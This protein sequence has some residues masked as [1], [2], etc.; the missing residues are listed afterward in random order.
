MGFWTIA[1]RDL[2]RHPMRTLL[3]VFSITIGVAAVISVQI[4]AE[5]ADRSVEALRGSVSGSFDLEI[6]Q[7]DGKRF[8][9]AEIEKLRGLP[10]VAEVLPFLHRTTIAYAK[11]K[12]I[13]A[14]AVGIDE[15]DPAALAD[16]QLTS[17]QSLAAVPPKSGEDGELQSPDDQPEESPTFPV[18]LESSFARLLG[19]T[20]GDQFTILLRKGSTTVRVVGLLDV[21]RLSANGHYGDIFLCLADL[22][23]LS[24]W[25]DKIDVACLVADAKTDLGKLRL[26]V[27]AA[28][29]ESLRVRLAGAQNEIAA[30]SMRAAKLGLIFAQSLAL[31]IAVFIILNNLLISVGQRRR[32][33][34][35]LRAVGATRWQILRIVLAEA[36]VFGVLGSVS[37][38]ALGILGA[39]FLGPALSRLWEA[40]VTLPEI[41]LMAVL[42]AAAL[43]PLVTLLGAVLPALGAT[44]VSPLEGI[45]GPAM[46]R[47]LKF[48]KRVVALAAVIWLLSFLLL[49][50]CITQRVAPMFSI[51]AGIGML[52]GFVLTIPPL[53]RPLGR[54]ISRLLLAP[55]FP[56]E[57]EIALRQLY[58]N[59]P[60]ATLT[61]AVIVIALSNGIGLGHTLI[62]TLADVQTWY[63]RTMS[64]DL[65]LRPVV[66]EQAA[67]FG[68]KDREFLGNRLTQ[69]PGCD[70]WIAFELPPDDLAT[71]TSR[72]SRA[73]L[74]RQPRYR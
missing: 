46:A 1:W 11:N 2:R 64:G 24:Y 27:A 43:G 28:L 55:W 21:R 35:L 62:N 3:N 34:S 13:T 14:V 26:E 45:R 50:G 72:S 6:T 9:A 54:G 58:R 18:L 23:S 67:L 39:R 73:I 63:R 41:S 69:F 68:I 61:T 37:G 32:N 65:F 47:E 8:D 22:Q 48:P 49:I 66:S 38:L 25:T 53:L 10:G 33:W 20:I 4:A 51:P 40:P 31:V 7:A 57:S 5:S 19:L 44:R 52:L 15:H 59:Q 36:L 71:K 16:F 30:A 17:G 42:L 74:P 56:G 60:R 12:R 70:S 29:P